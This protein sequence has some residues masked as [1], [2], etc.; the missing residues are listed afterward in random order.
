MAGFKDWFGYDTDA[1]YR[2]LQSMAINME[3]D[4]TWVTYGQVEI[5]EDE[6]SSRIGV[7]GMKMVY[8]LEQYET[9]WFVI[10]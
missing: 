2:K 6:S 10:R 4:D 5:P 7:T 8:L 3:D 9:D 1:G